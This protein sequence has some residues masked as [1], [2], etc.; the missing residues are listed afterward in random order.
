MKILLPFFLA[1][2]T[3]FIIVLILILL[4]IGRSVILKK[5]DTTL[6]YTVKKEGLVDTIQVSGTFTTA[7]QVA[8]ESPT[9]GAIT[10]FYVSNDDEVNKGDALFR[11]ESF[12][13]E[14]EKSSTYAKYLTAKKTLDASYADAY[15][16][17]SKKDAAWKEYVDIATDDTYENDDSTPR[18]DQRNSSAE[19]QSAQADWL[20]AEAHYKNQKAVI[21]AAQASLRS[22]YL[23]YQATTDTVIVAPASGTVVNLRKKVGD[24][25]STRSS[26]DQETSALPILLI[27]DFGNP[28]ITTT[29]PEAYIPRIAVGQKTTIVFD[30]MKDKTFTG[31]V[32]TIDTVG[33]DT[34]GTVTYN[35]R[36]AGDGMTETIKPNMSAMVVI[37][38]FRKESVF[39]VPNSAIIIKDGKTYVK[40]APGKNK[41]SLIPVELGTKG[42]AQTEIV[43]GL[44][45]GMV[46]MANPEQ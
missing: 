32:E 9:N 13:T 14:E 31:T 23:A 36:I 43:N 6:T 7:S 27:A 18:E 29:I 11:V 30:A 44:S 26:L 16:L 22:A 33:T 38:T 5:P 40:N 28:S 2:K 8:V 45:E 39:T 20:A 37:E 21:A 4:L 3:Y 24:Q 42:I 15:S 12:A 35:A 25:V 46:I 34:T 10:A 19:F 17:R 1:K 41:D